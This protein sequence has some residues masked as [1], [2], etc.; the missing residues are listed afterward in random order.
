MLPKIN[1]LIKKE[2]FDLVKEKGKRF[3]GKWF[4]TLVLE[5]GNNF[6]RLGFIISTK[7]SKKAILRNRTKRIL[8]EAVRKILFRTKPGFDIIILGKREILDKSFLEISGEVEKI[9]KKAGLFK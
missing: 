8:R 7:I 2:D 6:S 4:G 5:T 3:Q 9:F 1:R